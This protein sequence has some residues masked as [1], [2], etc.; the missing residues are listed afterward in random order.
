MKIVELTRTET[1]PDGTIGYLKVDKVSFC[2]T[3][4]PPDILNKKNVSAIPTGQYICRRVD[5]P[6][7]GITFE[8]QDV[9]DRVGV[10]FHKGNTVDDTHGCV[11]LAQHWGKLNGDR[12]I[13]NSG[14]TFDEFMEFMGVDDMFHLTIKEDY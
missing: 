13:L 11:I 4:E 2:V 10:L 6:K 1:G 14:K 12:A 8:I 9:P 5:S 3:L 7:F